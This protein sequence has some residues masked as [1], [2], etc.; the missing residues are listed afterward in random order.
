MSSGFFTR[1]FLGYLTKELKMS[2]VYPSWRYH[3][4]EAAKIIE[5]P[6]QDAALGKAWAESPA[7]FE[8]KSEKKSE[9]II[10]EELVKSADVAADIADEKPKRRGK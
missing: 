1:S 3:K 4:S 10:D 2:K 7:E 5:T 9:I 6:E 8:E